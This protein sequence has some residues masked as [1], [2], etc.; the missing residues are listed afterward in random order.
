MSSVLFSL[1]FIAMYRWFQITIQISTA[2]AVLMPN[3][4]VQLNFNPSLVNV[5][6][7][8][9]MHI[10]STLIPWTSASASASASSSSTSFHMRIVWVQKGFVW[11]LQHTVALFCNLNSRQ[12]KRIRNRRTTMQKSSKYY[13][14]VH[15]KQSTE[16]HYC[17]AAHHYSKCTGICIHNM[18]IVL[19]KSSRKCSIVLKAGIFY[20]IF[21]FII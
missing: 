4:T 20:S 6:I 21:Y 12:K 16:Q 8:A 14:N 3:K 17:L 19:E 11:L 18:C 10:H 13:Y 2:I 7:N 15:T 9:Q 5:N 1:V